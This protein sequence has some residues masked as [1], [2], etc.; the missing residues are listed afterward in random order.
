M[1]S[2]VPE[3]QELIER[4]AAL[5]HMLLGTGQDIATDAAE[6]LSRLSATVEQVSRERDEAR[7]EAQRIENVWRLHRGDVL[8]LSG[9]LDR[10]HERAEEVDAA[11][12]AAEARVGVLE[13]ALRTFAVM[14]EARGAN[15]AMT[16]TE[17]E[18]LQAA[19]E[20]LWPFSE[21]AAALP[22]NYRPDEVIMRAV[23]G[24]PA[25]VVNRDLMRAR[26]AAET[27]SALLSTLPDEADN[28]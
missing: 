26:T 13:E 16:R 23:K 8:S 12:Q 14:T 17:I 9:D 2:P 22:S 3:V 27:L 24:G 25:P 6:A 10:E 28:G 19:L 15:D 4:L 5:G 1:T 18:V 20:A 7:L 11:R 21:M